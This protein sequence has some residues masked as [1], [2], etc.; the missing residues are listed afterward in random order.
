MQDST[1]QSLFP[2]SSPTFAVKG[3]MILLCAA[4]AF[5]SGEILAQGGVIAAIVGAL[6]AFMVEML[7]TVVSLR[8][9]RLEERREQL[10]EFE[11]IEERVELLHSQ[12]KVFLQGQIAYLEELELATRKRLHAMVTETQRCVLHIRVYEEITLK[13][14]PKTKL[15]EFKVRTF[16]DIVKEFPLPDSP[17][18]QVH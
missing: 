12:E 15:P 1:L 4:L 6:V 9:H 7:R 10:K 16:E 14:E 5:V 3:F 17:R 2:T 8:R 11:V 13:S 18:I